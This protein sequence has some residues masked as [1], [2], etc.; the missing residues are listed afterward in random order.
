[1]IENIISDLNLVKILLAPLIKTAVATSLIEALFWYFCKFKSLKFLT[2]IVFVNIFSNISVNF[3]FV[4]ISRNIINELVIESLIVILEF[5]CIK[6]S[7]K[8]YA[9]L[10]LLKLTFLANLISYFSGVLYFSI[11]K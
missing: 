9:S 4:Y 3:L 11:F 10:K 1:M 5:L 8:K 6:L 7:F 2:L